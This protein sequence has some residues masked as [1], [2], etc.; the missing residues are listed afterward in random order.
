MEAESSSAPDVSA[1]A[2]ERDTEYERLSAADYELKFVAERWRVKPVLRWLQVVCRPDPAFPTG[3]VFTIYYDTPTLDCLHEKRNSDYLKTKVRLRWYRVGD[4]VSDIAFLETKSR[5]GSRREKPRLPLPY[6][7][8]W[9]TSGSLDVPS[10]RTVS[11]QLRSAGI[12]VSGDYQPVLL[13]RYRRHRFIEPLT[14][15]RASLDTEICAPA[16]SRARRLTPSPLPLPTTV[17]EFKGPR[18]GLPESLCP[19]TTLGFRKS[20]FSKYSACYDYTL[21]LA[22]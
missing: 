5:L 19:L 3:T 6:Q 10:L 8:S 2:P 13:V 14:G 17:F 22:G 7:P 1:A 20:S 11:R 18:D 15:L 9:P 12:T 4:R 21:E 16:V